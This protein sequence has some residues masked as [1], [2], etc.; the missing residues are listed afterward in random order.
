LPEALQSILGNLKA[1]GPRRLGLLGAA[2]AL[3]LLA[4]AGAAVMLN[5]P[6]FETLYIGL[7]RGDV[8]QIG[9]ALTESGIRFDVNSDGTAVLVPAGL[10]AQRPTR[11][12]RSTRTP[13]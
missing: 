5:R 2:G 10:T 7:E 8:N 9:L 13:A 12:G 3:V 4:V 11:R 6:A 1:M